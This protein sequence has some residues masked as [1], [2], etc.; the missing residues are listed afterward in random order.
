MQVKATTSVSG[1]PT[2]TTEAT[3]KSGSVGGFTLTNVSVSSAEQFSS[4]GMATLAA[5]LLGLV[6]V[7]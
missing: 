7:L 3:A 6:V 1:A 4:L 5:L 2:A